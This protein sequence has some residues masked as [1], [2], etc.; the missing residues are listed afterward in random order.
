[1]DEYTIWKTQDK[2]ALA[3]AVLE[4]ERGQRIGELLKIKDVTTDG[5]CLSCHSVNI[6]NERRMF[7]EEGSANNFNIRQ[8]VSCDGCH[9]PAQEW[10]VRHAG[11]PLGDPKWRTLSPQEKE[12]RYGM[13]N[14]RDPAKRAQMCMSCHVGSPDEGKIVTHAMMAAGHPPLPSFELASFSQKL[15]PHWYALKDTPYLQKA[16][17]EIQDKYH[18]GTADFQE[19]RLA[20]ATATVGMRNFTDLL[21]NRASWDGKAP[22][23]LEGSP[24]WPPPWLHLANFGARD[25]R[26]PEL[27]TNKL[28]GLDA[29]K[30]G[31]QWSQIAMAQSDC[32][33]CH[34]ELKSKSWRQLRGYD[35]GVPGRPPVLAWPFALNSLAGP[36]PEFDGKFRHLRS[37]LDAEP[38][39]NPAA[40]VKAADGL[41]KW[42]HRAPAE[43]NRKTAI[44]M[45]NNLCAVSESKYFDFESARQ[46]A[47][48]FKAIYGDVAGT[49]VPAKAQEILAALD[50][51]LC[52]VP[53]PALRSKFNEERKAAL[54]KPEDPITFSKA[55][56]AIADQELAAY[57][58][59]VSGYDPVAFKARLKELAGL[60][61]K[62]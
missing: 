26:W 14:L 11:P 35:G 3:H 22:E 47:M 54:K 13:F 9:G 39:G 53:N 58:T 49:D 2:H 29:D 41:S 15:P 8:G 32:Y 21:A 38:F 57:L 16:S 12:D 55:M 4:G 18:F 19:A 52:L 10:I 34:H 7:A 48:A 33:A 30:P 24:V 6:P 5:R 50:K 36:A 61:P 23:A 42:T 31:E 27:P 62:E 25:S 59:C 20:Q 56:Q 28:F 46:V 1:L 17:K 40:L 51:E 60:I 45:L 43:M 37:A 44:G